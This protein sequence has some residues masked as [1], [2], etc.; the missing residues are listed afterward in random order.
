M[1]EIGG[2]RHLESAMTADCREYQIAVDEPLV[3]TYQKSGG[4]IGD[5]PNAPF[6]RQFL[7][8]P[9]LHL[10]PGRWA[11]D[12]DAQLTMPQGCGEGRDV[13]LHASVTV[14]VQ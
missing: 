12:V 3:V 2:A 14:T 11:L 10:P 1:R 9:L 4:F 5:D 13:H 8:D 6:Y 7:E